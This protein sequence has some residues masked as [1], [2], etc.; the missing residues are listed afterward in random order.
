LAFH[1]TKHLIELSRERR[2]S[3]AA[4]RDIKPK[5]SAQNKSL[6]YFYPYSCISFKVAYNTNHS[7]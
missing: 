4:A 7:H 6:K 3:Y 2:S 1:A 5:N